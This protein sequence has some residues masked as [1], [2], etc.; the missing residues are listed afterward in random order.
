MR[1]LPVEIK[2]ASCRAA[3]SVRA[4]QKVARGRRTGA[5]LPPALL[6]AAL[7]LGGAA[8]DSYKNPYP[9]EPAPAPPTGAGRVAECL[10]AALLAILAIILSR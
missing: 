5:E 10:L 9:D 7:I 2:S 6:G 1:R 4:L 8:M 3:A